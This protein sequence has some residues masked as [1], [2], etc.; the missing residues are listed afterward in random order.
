MNEL[1]S[2]AEVFPSSDIRHHFIGQNDAK[3]IYAKELR[4]PAGMRLVSHEHAYDHLSILAAGFAML[5]VGA[6]RH[7]LCGPCA[8]TVKKGAPHTLRAIT[9]VVWFCIHPT[10]ETDAERVDGVIL[11]KEAV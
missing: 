1:Q 8:V 7:V 9:E 10:D 4:I 6:E 3:G 2:F 11:A 5:Q